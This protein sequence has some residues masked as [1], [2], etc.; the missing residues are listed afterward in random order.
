ML[1]TGGL[2]VG[3]SARLAK[4]AVASYGGIDAAEIEE[5]WHA[6]EPP[7]LSLF[8]WLDGHGPRPDLKALPVFRPLM[9]ANPIE[10]RELD[11]L[12]LADFAVE[13]KWD[14]ARVQI[15]AANGDVRLYA[16]GG[17]DISSGFPDIV[18]PLAAFTELRAVMDGELLVRHGRNAE[19]HELG[20]FNDLQKRLNR[21]TVTKAMRQRYP[22]FIYLYDLLM[23][24]DE[25]LRSLPFAERRR[26]LAALATELSEAFEGLFDL[27]PLI[28]ADSLDELDEMRAACRGDLREGLMLKRRSSA[29]V[30]G[31][32]RGAWYKYKRDPLNL[33]C[34][35]MYAQRGH[36]RR[37]SLYSDYTF[38]AWTADGTGGETLVPV[39]KAYFGFSDA[40]LTRLDKWVRDNTRNRFGPVREV[41]PG[42][43]LEI[44][45]DSVHHSQR[46]KSGVAMRFPR[47]LRIRWEKPPQEADRLETLKA[48][49]EH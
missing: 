10:Q 45:F 38:G 3:V 7:Y 12:T 32:P 27:S 14:G 24:G 22:A 13:W 6:L 46:H 17:D 36:G 49:I 20:G 28:D 18:E 1:V 23:L 29:Y 15:A 40:E 47:V 37:S 48:M 16:R 33:D 44:G 31:R 8:E 19:G 9:L 25:D 26:H 30:A 42:L 39:G 5:V 41:H 4:L 2:G 34:V 21:K 35:M 11:A 43:V